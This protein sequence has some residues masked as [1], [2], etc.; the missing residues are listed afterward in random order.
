V[1]FERVPSPGPYDPG[2]GRR[3]SI[4]LERT[5]DAPMERVWAVLRDYAQA[6]PRILTE[7]FGD[8]IIHQG[9]R[10]AGTVI[11]FEL[12]IGRRRGAYVVAVEEPTPGRQLR[13]RDRSSALVTTWTL[14]PAG[15]GERTLIHLAV[16]LRHPELNGWWAR[17]RARRAL[18][19]THGRLLERL[20]GDLAAT[21]SDAAA[22]RQRL[23]R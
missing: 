13:E 8:Y 17:A 12:R 7:H 3:L 21:E 1:T 6:R 16:D 9:G 15:E 5:L 19:R 11:G 18:R 10:G 2:P 20:A 23:D 22:G 4:A 14:T